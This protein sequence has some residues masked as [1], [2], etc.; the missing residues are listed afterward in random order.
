VQTDVYSLGAVLYELLTGEVPFP[1]DNFVAVA[2]RHI[3]EP[4][5]SVRAKRPD[6]SPRLDAAIKRAMAKDP[7]DRFETMDD[8]AAELQTCLPETDGTV[9]ST[10]AT[11]V[12]AAPKR[13]RRDRAPRPAA[14]RPSVWPLLLLLAGLAVL[15][16]IFAAV[17]AFTGSREKIP[18]IFGG[19]HKTAS[20]P[21]SLTGAASYDPEG[22]NGVEHPEAVRFAADG[23]PATFWTTE[24][25]SGGLNKSGVGVVLDAG[26]VKKLATLTV[27]TNTSGFTAVIKAGSSPS[28][29][30][31]P[32]SGPKTVSASTTF[33]LHASAARYYLVWI[34][35]LGG[36]SAVHVNEVTAKT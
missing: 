33:S 34:T 13:R 12:V 14:G 27:K 20:R 10:D 11:M 5:P 1:G 28:G 15:A 22:D 31:T 2:M 17:F 4:V 19:G 24:H 32:V 26:A 18:S 29:P 7:R 25:Y 3:N 21:V 6:V 23:N 35:D 16:G 36:N 9:S 8:F 30:F